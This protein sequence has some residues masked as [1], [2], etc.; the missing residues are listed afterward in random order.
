MLYGG[1]KV[2]QE[3]YLATIKIPEIKVM[4]IRQFNRFVG[5]SEEGGEGVV[6]TLAEFNL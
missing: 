4:T 6:Y 1:G 3:T 5:E 2:K